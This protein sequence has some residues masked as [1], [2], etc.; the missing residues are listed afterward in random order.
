MIARKREIV[1]GKRNRLQSAAR[2]LLTAWRS[3]FEVA[4]GRIHALSPLAILERGYAICR[5]EQ[6]AILR[7]AARVAAGDR[8][9]VK[10]ARGEID[11]CVERTQD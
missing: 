2:T 1:A 7:D 5:D 8:V 11:C 10:L 3:K 4:V 6:G 9:S